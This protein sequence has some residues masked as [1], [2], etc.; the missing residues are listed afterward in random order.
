MKKQ[1]WRLD[2]FYRFGHLFYLQQKTWFWWLSGQM[3][4]LLEESPLW[5][6]PL[7]Q[8]LA[9]DLWP[10]AVVGEVD[11]DCE[12][13]AKQ[14][15]RVLEVSVSWIK[16]PNWP[17]YII[18]ILYSVCTYIIFSTSHYIL[19]YMRSVSNPTIF[20][21]PIESSFVQPRHRMALIWWMLK[22]LSR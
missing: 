15:F 21:L 4:L 8:V 7:L 19:L 5:M 16:L 3:D 6:L 18:F 9:E 17:Q 11:L 12:A 14:A 20:I 13:I 1:A 2:S 10:R 22:L